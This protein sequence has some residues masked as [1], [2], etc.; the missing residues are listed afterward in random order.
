MKVRTYCGHGFFEEHW[1][2][3]EDWCKGGD[4]LVLAKVQADPA[5]PSA[6]HG[7]WIITEGKATPTTTIRPTRLLPPEL[8][9]EESHV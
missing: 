5:R 8:P 4:T 9:P 2:T 6:H 1:V 7:C 3:T